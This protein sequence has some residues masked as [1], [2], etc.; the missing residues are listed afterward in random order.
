M[1]A[2]EQEGHKLAT[3]VLVH[4]AYHGAWCWERLRRRL[5]LAGH[6]VF[7]DDLPGHGDAYDPHNMTLANYANATATLV[8]GLGGD[9]HL[10]GHSMAGAVIAEV[11]ERIPDAL[12]SLA[13]LTA[14]LPENGQ[15]IADLARHDEQ[16]RIAAQRV[17]VDGVP[18]LELSDE[19]LQQHFYPDANADQL[20]WVRGK[21]HPQ[22]IAPF[23][24]AVQLTPENFG[25]VPR[26]YIHCEKDK[27]IGL[28]LQR[29]ME[30]VQPCDPVLRLPGGHSP[31][32]TDVDA[33]ASVLH[34][35]A[36]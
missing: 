34:E 24:V 11:A 30:A 23:T 32:V 35:L 25:R 36:E 4:G 18:C 1:I 10:V 5:E 29:R 13:F 9:V 28:F 22:A 12:T 19:V 7:A 16:V 17:D 6:R 21:L 15:S 27:A 14:Y 31:F 2:S 33:L 3:F 8:M 20:D 26:A